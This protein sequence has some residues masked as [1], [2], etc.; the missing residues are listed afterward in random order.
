MTGGRVVVLGRT[1]KNFAAGMSGGV[2][3]VLD[4]DNVLYKNL[5]K[6]LILLEKVE[7]KFD[8]QE[9]RGLIEAHVAAT[10]S[11]IGKRVLE[12]FE[13]SLKHFKKI[14]PQEYKKVVSL[15]ASLEEKGVPA[16]QAQ[17]E[18]F[19]QLHG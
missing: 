17:M 10:G 5:N 1:G 14:I 7:N 2:A 19:M 15:S 9:L 6:E 3:Y 4:E 11:A 16:E 13:E 18:A 12:N 8:C